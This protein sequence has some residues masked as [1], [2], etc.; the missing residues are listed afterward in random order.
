MET[1][2]LYYVH[3]IA[4]EVPIEETIGVMGDLV[5][6][7]K[8]RALGLS[9]VS[10]MTLRQAHAVHPIAAVQSEYSLWNR[11]PELELLSACRELQISFVAY[12]P[13]GRGMLT[14]GINTNTVFADNDFRKILPRF[15]REHLEANLSLL[16]VVELMALEKQCTPSQISLAWLLAQGEDIIPIPGTRHIQY[17][18]Q[19][20]TALNVTMDAADIQRLNQALPIGAAS[21]ARYP[22]AGMKGIS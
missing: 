20:L 15:Q 6:T 13:L 16:E 10:E 9:E 2:D 11:D 17:L 3:R 5:R 21:G 18:E 14:G 7:G 8:V 1:I 22:A 19:N 4:P 12:S